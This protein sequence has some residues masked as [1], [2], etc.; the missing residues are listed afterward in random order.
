[1]APKGGQLDP[2]TG[3]Q[4]VYTAG[5][6]GTDIVVAEGTT[7]GGTPVKQT[8]TLIVV[9]EVVEEV[10]TP[11]DTLVP[12]TETPT[13]LT[14]QSPITITGIICRPY[15]DPIDMDGN[16]VFLGSDH[17]EQFDGDIS[18]FAGIHTIFQ[19][20]AAVEVRTD[21]HV[22]DSYDL[23]NMVDVIHCVCNR[24]NEVE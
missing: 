17:F 1:M 7:A 21:A 2:G 11:T 3:E 15:N 20:A 12:P 10:P 22:I 18:Q 4:V 13:P 5:K 19:P 14:I 9:G 8:V 24:S 16:K 23:D 6:E